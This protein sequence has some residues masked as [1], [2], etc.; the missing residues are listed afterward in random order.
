[1]HGSKPILILSINAQHENSLKN[2]EK[3]KMC[4]NSKK[5]KICRLDFIIIKFSFLYFYFLNFIHSDFFHIVIKLM[6]N[7]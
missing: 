2:I 1:M 7:I 5:N 4:E 3:I 6:M